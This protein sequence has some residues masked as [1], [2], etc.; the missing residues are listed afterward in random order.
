MKKLLK[1]IIKLPTSFAL[2]PITIKT[3]FVVFIHTSV[4]LN[5]QVNT[6]SLKKVLSN[7]LVDSTRLSINLQLAKEFVYLNVTEAKQ[8]ANNSIQLA[9]N[10]S[11]IAAMADAHKLL[12]VAYDVENKPKESINQYLKA[13]SYYS[14]LQD[15]LSIA[16]CEVNIGMLY[17][18]T[19]VSNTAFPYFKRSEAVFRKNG[20][21]LGLQ[22]AIQNEGICF[23]NVR[24][25]DSALVYFFKALKISEE[26]NLSDGGALTNIGNCY[27]SLKQF[28]K[29]E[30]YYMKSLKIHEE[31][32]EFDRSY[33]HCKL[34]LSDVLSDKN[35]NNIPYLE[36]VKKGYEKLGITRDSE[37][38]K[39]LWEL[40]MAYKKQNRFN[41]AIDLLSYSTLLRDTLLIEQ[42]AT[43][44]LELNEQYQSDKKDLE[45]TNI[46]KEKQLL[47]VEQKLRQNFIYGLIAGTLVLIIFLVITYNLLKQ[48]KRDNLIITNQKATLE[49]RNNEKDALIQE[50][51]H[52]V[53]NNLQFIAAMIKMQQNTIKLEG[54]RKELSEASRRI[55]TMSLVHE[56]LYNKERLAYVSLKE[57]I[58]ELVS[59]LNELIHRDGKS[60]EFIQ[61]I[62]DVKFDINNSVALGMLTSEIVSN[63]I[64]YAFINTPNPT[65]SLVL[66]YDS[67]A[68][69]IIYE[70]GDNGKGMQI[71]GNKNGLGM[72]LIDIFSRQM[73]AEYQII[74]D[75][76]LKYIFKIPY[77]LK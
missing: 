35:K 8:Y 7:K 65:V 22:I 10:L 58:L 12:G 13:I 52:R 63:A 45:L 54:D 6:D 4:F 68:K 61:D 24:N 9:T 39:C 69:S 60:I 77:E 44:M 73:E 62:D 57:Y 50:I 16:K 55:N 2:K 18:N 1:A 31:N 43:K 25:F 28:D 20:F 23:Y 51:H 34:M 17:L 32:Q 33:Y 74:N 30:E 37:Y 40:A 71:G 26:N 75:N 53:K 41:E 38:L 27:Y 70:I 36:D 5:A 66:K 42:S 3:V 46:N 59:R 19:K 14:K 64:K 49:I 76:G 29:A 21:V 56:M 11:N 72:R 47:I 48:K 15:S 67:N